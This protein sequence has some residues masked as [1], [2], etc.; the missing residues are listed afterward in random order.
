MKM[1]IHLLAYYKNLVEG[2]NSLTKD[3]EITLDEGNLEGNN[4]IKTV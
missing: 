1:Q 3:I 2:I 4:K